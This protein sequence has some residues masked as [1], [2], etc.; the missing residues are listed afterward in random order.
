MMRMTCNIIRKN[1]FTTITTEAER[2]GFINIMSIYEEKHALYKKYIRELDTFREFPVQMP[3]N[4]IRKICDEYIQARNSSWHNI[5]DPESKTLV[6]FVIIGKEFP[7]KH[8][9]SM[10]SVAQ[11]YVLP[12]YRRKGLM[13]SVMADYMTRHEGVYSL[14]ILEGNE[15]AKGFWKKF[16]E[17]EGY[18][19]V[20]LA[21]DPEGYG[22]AMLFGYAPK[23]AAG[24]LP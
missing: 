11:A 5:Y 23:P 24:L 4:D 12:K 15:Y 16:F 19:E 20:P 21:P 17:K 18:E 10:R 22:E 1:P 13:T 8:P 3:E 7:E 2:E 14:L 9:D 6:G